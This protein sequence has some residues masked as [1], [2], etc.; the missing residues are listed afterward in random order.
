MMSGCTEDWIAPS[1]P[2]ETPNWLVLG[3]VF[4]DRTQ[5]LNF[6]GN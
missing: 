5:Y 6:K 2:V 4:V 3:S 1:Y